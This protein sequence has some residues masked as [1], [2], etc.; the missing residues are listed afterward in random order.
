MRYTLDTLGFLTLLVQVVLPVLVAVVTRTS[1]SAR[2]KSLTLLGLT[3]VTQFIS[4]W[5]DGFA[6]FDL[7]VS[8]FNA[9]IGL[10]VSVATYYGVW[11]PTGT[12]ETASK[13]GPQ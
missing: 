13:L 7:R 1:A 9:L 4:S 3:A 2:V 8:G 11:K 10:A 6:N 12:S 5:I